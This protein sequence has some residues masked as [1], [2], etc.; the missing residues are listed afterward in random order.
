M[1]FLIWIQL[2]IQKVTDKIPFP[3]LLASRVLLPA[4]PGG[5]NLSTFTIRERLQPG[6]SF[7]AGPWDSRLWTVQSC[8]PSSQ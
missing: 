1:S 5:I 7:F 2:L 6:R 4:F 3:R 8:R